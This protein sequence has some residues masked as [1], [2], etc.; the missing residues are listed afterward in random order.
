VAAQG[1]SVACCR[2]LLDAGA[3][4]NARSHGGLTARDTAA[5]DDVRAALAQPVDVE[6]RFANAPAPSEPRLLS[7]R[8]SI[9][10][11]DME[12]GPAVSV[13]VRSVAADFTPPKELSP[14]RRVRMARERSVSSPFLVTRKAGASQPPPDRQNELEMK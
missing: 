9:A 14:A 5:N 8:H 2:A 13:V 1:G 12:S 4:L 11:S 10:C 7:R 3:D 6:R